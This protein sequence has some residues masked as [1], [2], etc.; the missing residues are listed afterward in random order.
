MDTASTLSTLN[1]MTLGIVLLIAIGLA[2]WFFR[3]KEN[4]HPMGKD[5]GFTTDIDAVAAA[6]ADPPR[7]RDVRNQS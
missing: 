3:K 4:R 7:A 2:A 5:E 6:K 1:M